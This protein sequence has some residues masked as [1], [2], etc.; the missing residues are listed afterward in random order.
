MTPIK[1]DN[2]LPTPAEL[3]VSEILFVRER[4]ER[5]LSDWWPELDTRSN[6]VF[7]DLV[8]TPMA[9]MT[10][11]LEAAYRRRESDLNLANVARGVVFDPEFVDG[12]LNNFGATSRA[13]VASSGVIRLAFSEDRA[14]VLD[15]ET[16]FVLNGQ[17]FRVGESEGNPLVIVA[18]GQPG[19]R[20]LTRES[21]GRYTVLLP[22]Y[23]SP[24]AQVASNLVGT[25]SWNESRL[26]QVQA[27]GDFDSG[28]TGDSLA[29]RAAR[30]RYTFAAA[31]LV[32]RA[33]AESFVFSRFPG[34]TA[35]SVVVT[36]DQE[37]IR[38]GTNLLG[39]SE[40]MI[41]IHVR[42]QP[43][44]TTGQVVQRLAFDPVRDG[45]VGRLQLPVPP[46][47]M[48]LTN[49]VFQVGRQ[50]I[51]GGLEVYSRSGHPE[52][53]GLGIAYS[54]YEQLGIVARDNSAQNSTE[55]V[56]D[57]AD[58]QGGPACTITVSGNYTGSIFSNQVR[59]NLSFRYDGT[60]TIES[61][62]YARFNI[63]DQLTMESGAVLFG[64][65]NTTS[66]AYGKL[67]RMLDYD[68]FLNGL[69]VRIERDDAGG[70]FDAANFS[71]TVFSMTFAARS[72]DFQVNYLYD[73]A[74]LSVA[75]LVE[76]DDNKPVGTSVLTRNFVLCHV[77]GFQVNYR[78]SQGV[79][80]D[81]EG[82]RNAVFQ[83][84]SRIASPRVFE[85][86][87]IGVIVMRYGASGMVSIQAQGRFFPTMADTFVDKQGVETAVA[88]PITTTLIPESN[89]LGYGRRNVGYLV[90]Q[91]AIKFVSYQ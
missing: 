31:S 85:Q 41:D 54:K 61:V 68:E 76:N 20:S 45:W 60:T 55:A 86:S 59:R 73:P 28:L 13:S 23:G 52:I 26:T 74:I 8:L 7:G 70:V 67:E 2:F 63:R 6:S 87:V 36:G 49:G 48:D 38:E 91:D 1:L 5:Y 50:G 84:I 21:Q 77:Q 34:L 69:D 12:F 25:T 39:L 79:V 37:M 51:Q 78:P 3:P 22:V 80:F 44:F 90:S 81:V 71:G 15:T 65:D 9:T 11:A 19:R 53:D 46:A 72:A 4:L 88:H 56:T 33:G 83:Y 62:V 10:A 40:G 32:S 75:G 58:Q 27:A 47:F 18:A 30:V 29:A 89:S 16:R 42:S 64:P 35:A 17:S 43:V 24:G 14:Y 82:A 66:P 57:P